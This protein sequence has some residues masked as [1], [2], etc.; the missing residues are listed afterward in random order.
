M[1]I[2]SDIF[3]TYM[4][5]KRGEKIKAS[6]LPSFR[7]ENKAEWNDND[8]QWSI[9]LTHADKKMTGTYYDYDESSADW[10]DTDPMTD[11]EIMDLLKER[12]IIAA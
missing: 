10:K 1:K 2:T 11:D 6:S 12:K 9:T 7:D 4:K 5:P 3:N 8:G